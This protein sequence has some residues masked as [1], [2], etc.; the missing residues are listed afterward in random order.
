MSR[1]SSAVPLHRPGFSKRSSWQWEHL[2]QK[3]WLKLMH[4]TWLFLLPLSKDTAGIRQFGK[5]LRVKTVC[6]DDGTLSFKLR[7]LVSNSLGLPWW[8]LLPKVLTVSQKGYLQCPVL[9]SSRGTCPS[10]SR[11]GDFRPSHPSLHW[12]DFKKGFEPHYQVIVSIAVTWSQLS[13]VC[14]VSVLACPS[15]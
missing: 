2:Q 11:N 12:D 15:L 1:R 9:L 4:L 7:E 8:Y 5:F 13:N 14:C 6:S 3:W 10:P